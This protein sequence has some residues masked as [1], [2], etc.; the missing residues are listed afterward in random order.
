MEHATRP[1][2]VG[3][4]PKSDKCQLPAIGGEDWFGVCVDGGAKPLKAR[5]SMLEQANKTVVKAIVG[6]C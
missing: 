2:I 6:K 1:V 3:P 5:G 4:V